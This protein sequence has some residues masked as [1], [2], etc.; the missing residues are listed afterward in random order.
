[1]LV[2]LPGKTPDI[3]YNIAETSHSEY[4]FKKKKCLPLYWKYRVID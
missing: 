3:T 1:M 4:L 2:L